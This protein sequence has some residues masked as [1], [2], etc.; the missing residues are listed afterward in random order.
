MP[1]GE[2]IKFVSVGGRT[3]AY[4]P[5]LQK[6]LGAVSGTDLVGRPKGKTLAIKDDALNEMRTVS[7]TSRLGDLSEMKEEKS[8]VRKRKAISKVK[9]SPNDI[10]APKSKRNMKTKAENFE[11]KIEQKISVKKTTELRRSGRR[12]PG[13]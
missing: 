6:I 11:Q 7:T 1:S 10:Q 8:V 3:S 2:K 12:K 13:S 9:V 5:T 4:I